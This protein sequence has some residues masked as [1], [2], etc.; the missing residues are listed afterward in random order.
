MTSILTNEKYMGAA[1][2]QKAFTVDF[3][4]KKM[5]KNDGEVPQYYVE[6]SHPG[7]IPPDEWHRV[8]A[9]IAR[10]K[11]LNGSYVG[12]STFSAKIYCGDCGG[13]YGPKVWHSTDKYRRTIWQC[14]GKFKGEHRCTTTHLYEKDIKTLFLKAY[15]ELLRERCT[16]IEDCRY[17]QQRL[18]DTSELESRK[19]YLTDE[20][21][22]TEELIRRCVEDNAAKAQ[23]QGEYFEKYE[24]YAQRYEA[25]KAEFNVLE[26][27]RKERRDK[28]DVIGSFITTLEASENIQLDFDDDT[29]TAVI[30]RI[31][32]Y[33]DE[34]I[35]FTFR[36]GVTITEQL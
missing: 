7:I 2:L 27:E 12:T 4:S 5:K 17:V 19:D 18:C 24:K 31:T 26:Q 13:M 3:L 35:D 29:F 33:A 10:R 20:M 16:V 34:H 14:N 1:L 23:N 15:G 8:Q 11:E 32:V 21:M 25:L 30:E 22:V 9:E 6:D 36:G 28:Y